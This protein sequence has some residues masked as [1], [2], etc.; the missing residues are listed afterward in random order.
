MKSFFVI[1]LVIALAI[2]F[3]TDPTPTTAEDT[4]DKTSERYLY[5]IPA[6]DGSNDKRDQKKN[7][8]TQHGCPKCN[9]HSLTFEG[10]STLEGKRIHLISCKT[11]S[12]EWQET[13]TLPNWFWLISSSSDNHWTS[14]GWNKE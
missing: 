3:T 5:D 1:F 12:F 14:E 10:L 11:C 9:S 4:T 2:C 8:E 7:E 6:R 13:W